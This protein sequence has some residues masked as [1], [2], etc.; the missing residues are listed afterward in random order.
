MNINLDSTS[1]IITGHKIVASFFLRRFYYQLAYQEP[2]LCTHQY[3]PPEG[4]GRQ[5]ILNLGS[6][7]ESQIHTCTCVKDTLYIHKLENF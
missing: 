6:T 4:M 7:Q 2:Y 1:I 5:N 3:F